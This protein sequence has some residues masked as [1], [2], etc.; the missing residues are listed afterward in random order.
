MNIDYKTINKLTT[1]ELKFLDEDS[2][3]QLYKLKSKP[4]LRSVNFWSSLSSMVKSILKSRT[5]GKTDSDLET[6]KTNAQKY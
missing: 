4:G 3:D 5:N 6:S 1:D 2:I